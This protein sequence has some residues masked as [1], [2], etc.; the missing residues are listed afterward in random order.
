MEPKT[1]VYE[2]LNSLGIRYEVIDHPA[3]FTIE[4]L[5]A[6]EEFRNNSWVAKNL[7]LRD[8]KGRRHFLV[9]LDKHKMADI[10]SIRAQ[11]GSS[12]LSFAS[13]ERL[14]RYLKL[15]KGSVT[16]MGIMNDEDHSVEVVFD[17]DLV[18]RDIIGV[19]PNDN[20]ATV[21]LSYSDL[22]H[23]IRTYGNPIHIIDL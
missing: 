13:E 18:G 19:H 10:R 16:P 23:I 22:Y 12:H 7:F 21:L 1:K 2:L 9:M 6:L 4:D 14:M 3:A 17:R 8:E 11:L 20:T 15:T 5:D